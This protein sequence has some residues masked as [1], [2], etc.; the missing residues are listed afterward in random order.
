ML[1]VVPQAASHLPSSRKLKFAQVGRMGEEGDGATTAQASCGE[2]GA[3]AESTGQRIAARAEGGQI[4]LFQP[5]VKGLHCMHIPLSRHG[6]DGHPEIKTCLPRWCNKLCACCVCRG[7]R[8]DRDEPQE[9]SQARWA[10]AACCR[11][12]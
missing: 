6:L 8:E 1:E 12:A 10:K 4:P 7:C 2:V 11:L 5:S 9:E 3:H